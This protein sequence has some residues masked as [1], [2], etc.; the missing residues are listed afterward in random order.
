MSAAPD[1]VA[2]VAQINDELADLAARLTRVSAQVADLADALPQSSLDTAAPVA[3]VPL[4]PPAAAQPAP[5]RPVPPKNRIA[6]AP[7]AGIPQLQYATGAAH[8]APPVFTPPPFR[9]VPAP[10]PAPS[11]LTAASAGGQLGKVL[12]F[13]GVA[14]TLIGVVLLLV[15]AA[16]AGLL[17]AEVRVAGGTL[18]A[19]ALVGAG[20]L[21]GRSPAKRSAAA[22]LVA[23]GIAA[24]LFCVLAATNLYHWLPTIAALVLAGAI[25][26]VGFLL[27]ARWDSQPLG[28]AVGTGLALLAP[29][30]SQGADLTLL[31]FLL[32]YAAAALAVQIGRDWTALF[33]VNTVATVVPLLLLLSR[34]IEL[35][36]AQFVIGAAVTFALAAGSAVIL[37]RST[38]APV[39]VA[40]ISLL[41]LF[42]IL[43][44][45][46]VLD[47][48][49]AALLLVG[50]SAALLVLTLAGAA[51]IRTT[52]GARTVWL[53]GAAV[54][55]LGAAAVFGGADWLPLGLLGGALALG[56]VSCFGS[57][58]VASYRV[59]GTVALCAGL[60]SIFPRAVMA[61][62]D[63]DWLDAPHRTLVFTASL[64]ALAA[65]TTLGWSWFHQASGSAATTIACVGGLIALALIN[66]VCVASAALVT[67]GSDAGFRSGHLSATVIFAVAGG[68]G[69]M[70]ARR[71]RGTN[72]A[73]AM[74]SGL[75]VLATA[76]GKLFLF[77]LSA[78][79][80]I[81][82]VLAFIVVGLVLL[83]L[84]VAYAQ[85]LE[86][87]AADSRP[88][89]YEDPPTG[90]IPVV[91]IPV[92]VTPQ[93]HR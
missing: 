43:G 2:A 72:R 56:L 57:D 33:A 79:D 14:I 34:G 59:L 9:P 86:D 5:V 85:S 19:A 37:L 42:P 25:A 50:I 26:A 29:F 92:S 89:S 61:L 58:L 22:A 88:S 23:T 68:A 1:P 16:Q 31:V 73:L 49:P 62:T 77:D 44:G 40:L 54:A 71:L 39:A 6:T 70:W 17:A 84:G 35:P 3:S 4:S 21:V 12:A 78:L 41:P 87:E 45:D 8:A 80:G 65:V 18:L 90:P 11:R 83:G 69:L 20:V 7:S 64:L 32:V 30:L 51:P 82:R 13:A 81:F 47:R 75:L 36:T 55:A 93:K 24:A 91:H 48:A 27:A 52:V 53:T 28:L 67:G 60:L 74:T 10:A 38:G 15:L 63:A 46:L 76:V 66:V